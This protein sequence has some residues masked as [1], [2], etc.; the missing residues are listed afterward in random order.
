MIK[1]VF[2]VSIIILFFYTNFSLEEEKTSKVSFYALYTWGSEFPT[3]ADDVE[4]V[5]FKWLRVGGPLLNKE[6]EEG[7]LDAAKRGIRCVLVIGMSDVVDLK[8]WREFVKKCLSRYCI[9]GSLWKENPNIKPLPIEYIE[10]WN[11]PN[12]E[13]LKPPEGQKRD[14]CYYECLKIAYEEIKSYNPNIKVIGMNT[15]G[16]ALKVEGGVP[17]NGE[18]K[19]LF[20]WFKFIKDVNKLGGGKYYDIIGTH[21]Y[22]RNKAPE[23]S[24]LVK[25]LDEIREEL[26]ANA[27]G[28]KPIWFT[29][30][31]YSLIVEG[32]EKGDKVKDEDMQAD[33]LLRLLALAA[34]HGVEQ[35][36]IMYISDIS[37]FHA[38]LFTRSKKWRKQATAIKVMMELMPEPVLVKTISEGQEGYYAYEFKGTENKNVI[39]AWTINKEPEEKELDV[40]GVNTITLVDKLG[41]KQILTVKNNKVKVKISES[42]IY[43]EK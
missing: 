4:K 27:G 1:R 2:L 37:Y 24:G 33:Y 8:A 38:G 18:Y 43:L 5:G 28:E 36:Q 23:K 11:E 17:P 41:N 10:V 42:P 21:P 3:F 40:G 32:H 30:V 29:E 16:G 14:Q 31:G 6:T 26:K 34:S 9:N 22:T 12:I 13:Y 35:V 19:G 25:A 15:S 20:G 39:M 7:I